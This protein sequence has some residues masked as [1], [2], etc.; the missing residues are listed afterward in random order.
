MSRLTRFCSGLI[1]RPTSTERGRVG[2]RGSEGAREGKG[3]GTEGG[4]K[5]EKEG[6][7]ERERVYMREAFSN[8]SVTALKRC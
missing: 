1:H 7:R 4:T 3:E 6:E 2:E 8:V 5:E